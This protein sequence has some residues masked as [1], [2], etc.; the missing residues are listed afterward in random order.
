[1][2]DVARTTGQAKGGTPPVIGRLFMSDPAPA[3]PSEFS[4]QRRTL[5]KLLPAAVAGSAISRTIAATSST[6]VSASEIQAALLKLWDGPLRE[7]SAA[8][9]RRSIEAVNGMISGSGAAFLSLRQHGSPAPNSLTH[10][11]SFY[12]E[13]G[14]RFGLINV[15][16]TFR[17]TTRAFQSQRLVEHCYLLRGRDGFDSGALIGFLR[18]YGPVYGQRFVIYK[19][20]N[21]RCAYLIGTTDGVVPKKKQSV[22]IG[23][24]KAERLPDFFPLLRSD[25]REVQVE[26]IR[27][28]YRR[29]YVRTELEH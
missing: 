14:R 5:L 28:P 12:E 16:V 19:P 29:P 23:D 13:S 15:E 1:M 7:P 25:S 9:Q 17:Q 26:R 21:D 27:F 2:R 4:N 6:P 10:Q 24:F 22:C 11:R 8:I 18:Q 20:Y 3:T